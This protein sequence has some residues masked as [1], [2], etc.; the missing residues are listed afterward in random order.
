MNWKTIIYLLLLVI[1][2]VLGILV[3]RMNFSFLPLTGNVVGGSSGNI[4][5]AID[6]TFTKAL[7]NSANECIDLKIS[8]SNG[9]VAGI[10][11]VSEV[12]QFGTDWED[13][14]SMDMI[15]GLC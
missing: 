15:R 3:S 9:K 4:N 14:R 7:C 13:P 2:F 8:C 12:T 5:L 6:H 11:M 1:A 10:E